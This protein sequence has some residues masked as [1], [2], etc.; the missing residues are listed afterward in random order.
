[1]MG[2]GVFE[3]THSQFIYISYGSEE[4]RCTHILASL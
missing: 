4:I 1:M 2:T 3:K